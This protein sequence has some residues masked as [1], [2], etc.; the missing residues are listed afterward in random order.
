MRTQDLNLLMIFDA[1]MT[2][3]AITRAA[4]RLA[5]TQPAVSNALSRMRSAWGDELFVKDGRGIQPTSF[6]KN[7]WSQ[8]QAPL[9]QLED[10]VNPTQFTPATAKRTFR[11]AATDTFVDMV[12]GPLRQIIESEAPGINI[13]AVPNPSLESDKILKDAEAELAISKYFH[14][15]H[16]IRSEHILD[17]RYV[18]VMRP[19]HPLAKRRLALQEF[20]EAEHLL[21]SVTGDV[22]GPT[23]QALMNIGM[24]RRVAMSVNN[25]YN[26]PSLLKNS[27]LIC[28]APSIVL[29][30]EIFSG[31][32][33]VFETPVEIAPTPISLLWH[34]R[35]EHDLGLQW[36]RRHVVR[37]VH[38]RVAEHEAMV[39]QCCRKGYCAET[40]KHFKEQHQLDCMET[41]KSNMKVVPVSMSV[42]K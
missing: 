30:K 38:Q 6:A 37:I 33:A 29:E 42:A 22:T 5:M 8:I 25:F 36:L 41:R 16:V 17:P 34:K 39:A 12:W 7:M 27:N 14:P 26:V 24:T 28:V 11:I 31:D 2:E 20:V 9:S 4:D 15:E 40:V 32:L 23:D 18:V 13:Y 21:V 35:Q 10:A 19:D 1:I 3:G